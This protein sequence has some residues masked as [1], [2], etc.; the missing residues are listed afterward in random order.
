MT[1]KKSI[2]K[3]IIEILLVNLFIVNVFISSIT[4]YNLNSFIIKSISTVL[5]FIVVFT[6][7][8]NTRFDL[9]DHLKSSQFKKL[10]SILVVFL[11][12]PL[13]SLSYSSNFA[14]G[15]QKLISL[16]ISTIPTILAFFYILLTLNKERFHTFIFSIIIISFISV[17]L[18]LIIEPFSYDGSTPKSLTTWSHVI[19]GRFISSAYI[20]IFFYLLNLKNKKLIPPV[21][22]C[23]SIIII[24]IFLSG[25]R[26]A[27]LGA[28]I[29]A[30]LILI[31]YLFQKKLRVINLSGL[32]LSIIVS[33][34]LINIIP[35]GNKILFNRFNNLQ[36]IE[37][38]RFNYDSPIHT[39]Y[40]SYDISIEI[41]KERPFLGT[42]FGGFR[43][44]N[45]DYFTQ[46]IKYPHNIFLEF[47]VELGIPGI[48]LL[49]FL[50]YIIFSSTKKISVEVLLFF[51]FA[52]WLAM[53]SKD[54]P[55]Q[56]LLWIGLAFYGLKE[57]KLK[58]EN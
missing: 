24:G 5:L 38:F 4:T 34:L 53:F 25:L 23:L 9:L 10:L 1:I 6:D 27:L 3:Y 49:L 54:I 57:M 21:S 7:C 26:A 36:D 46:V 41:I 22:L 17:I 8:K 32:L 58:I 13:I 28:F 40:N 14:F 12:I 56:S 42:G 52:L 50:L 45:D 31:I 39:R 16:S 37:D 15:L 51:L 2:I 35:T 19:Y 48:L 33:L 18:I 47:F 44:Y 29:F 55:S 11:L 30:L 20:I 43:N